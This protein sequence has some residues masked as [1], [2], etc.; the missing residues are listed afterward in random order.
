MR[1]EKYGFGGL[2]EFV[3]FVGLAGGLETLELGGFAFAAAG[4][5]VFLELEVAQLLFILTADF[6]KE[7]GLIFGLV[8]KSWVAFDD[9]GG[10]AGDDGEFE[11][12]RG[13]ETPTSVDDGLDESAF[14][15]TEGLIEVLILCGVAVVAVGVFGIGEKDGGAGE[16]MCDGVEFGFGFARIGDRTAGFLG[17]L[18]I[19]GETRVRQSR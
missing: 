7:V 4:E 16:A 1:G 15:G 2:G 11:D 6:E 3:L 12:G 9:G 5:A 17:V 13:A 14:F 18:S 19:G 10:A 8:P